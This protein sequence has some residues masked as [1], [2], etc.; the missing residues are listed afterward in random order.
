MLS[1]L[2]VTCL[3]HKVNELDFC[4]RIS[5]EGLGF[6]GLM[7]CTGS[8]IV[9][10]GSLRNS[11]PGNIDATEEAAVLIMLALE[12]ESRRL[13]AAN[14]PQNSNASVRGSRLSTKA[15]ISEQHANSN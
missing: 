3:P 4:L 11:A 7:R 5:S 8:K 13:T 15:L 12:R 9:A 1:S 6:R 10:R 2:D 14:L